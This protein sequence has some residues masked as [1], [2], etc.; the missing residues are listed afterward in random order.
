M[1]GGGGSQAP[2]LNGSAIGSDQTKANV[3]SG[4]STSILNNT[5]QVTPFG[6]LQYANSGGSYDYN[7]NWIPQY[8]ATQ[9]L[10]PGQQGLLDSRTGAQ[11]S[12]FDLAQSYFPQ[13]A[14]GLNT[15]LPN[16]APLPDTTQFQKDAYN[17]LTARS[18]LALNQQTDAQKV[19]NAN[20]GVAT[21]STAYNRSL[22]PLEQARV[23]ASNQATINAGT[24]A[25]QYI[26]RQITGNN[27]QL[28][29]ALTRQNA[30]FQLY[31]GIL[32]AAGG[33]TMP[34]FV[35]TPQTQIQAPDVTSPQLA[36]FNAQQQD[37]T[38]SLNRST[39]GSNALTGSLF[40]LGGAALAG[41][42]AGPLGAGLFGLGKAALPSIA[43][44]GSTQIYS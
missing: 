2:S 11:Q 41:T 15:P 36:S 44:T 40:G 5:N 3:S 27:Y 14:A 43:R 37:Y 38:N 39:S 24:L 33:P 29:D 20:Q 7:G 23:D 42:L 31:S 10:S 13:V 4:I 17:A 6:G 26:N 25:D 19:Q 1:Q 22:Q 21:G 35:N 28:N 12:L 8:T 32:G 9:T 30:P 18:D 34:T 16:F